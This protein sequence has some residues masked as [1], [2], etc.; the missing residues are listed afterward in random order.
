MKRLLSLILILALALPVFTDALELTKPWNES[1]ISNTTWGEI[2]N[3][4]SFQLKDQRLI[5][6][7][8]FNSTVD[9]GL[10]TLTASGGTITQAQPIGAFEHVI[11]N[12]NDR[13]GF[14]CNS[15]LDET[16]TDFR[17]KAIVRLYD[18]TN[19][20]RPFNFT[21]ETT[22]PG[23]LVDALRLYTVFRSLT[24]LSLVYQDDANS[25]WSWNG[26][27]WINTG[28]STV[29]ISGQEL[30]IYVISNTTNWKYRLEDS[31]GNLITETDSVDWAD[32]L[33]Q[34]GKN[35]YFM[36]FQQG[37]SS[38]IADYNTYNIEIWPTEAATTFL[39]SA[40]TV[41]TNTFDED[42]NSDD[43]TVLLGNS[44][45]GATEF[46]LYVK[47][48]AGAFGAAININSTTASSTGWWS[49]SNGTSFTSHSSVTFKVELNS[50]S[51]DTQLEVRAL[52]VL[53]VTIAGGGADDKLIGGT[54]D[55]MF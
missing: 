14:Y 43:V 17:I 54:L 29:S 3:S 11:P 16:A 8:F 46:K 2:S 37:N 22:V 30:I 23:Q 51:S 25:A 44:P 52:K 39:T 32:T 45:S 5:F 13:A 18:L 15:V 6:E 49:F 21:L 42:F 7:D 1:S 34:G 9:A 20:H 28:L 38:S 33:A 4:G 10:V 41:E 26:A 53:G 40:Q 19:A 35:P 55:G 47:E 50:P 27:A 12:T 48:D 31:Q 24:T 36:L